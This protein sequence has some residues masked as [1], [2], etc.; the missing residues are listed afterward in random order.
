MAA[1]TVAGYCAEDALKPHF[2]P[3]K[4]L[5]SIAAATGR[6]AVRRP[7]QNPR[8]GIVELGFRGGKRL[9]KG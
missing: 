8:L 6:A 9:R 1:E 4:S 7:A 5:G 3:G 2:H